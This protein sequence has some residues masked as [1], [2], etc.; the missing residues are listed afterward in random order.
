MKK[1]SNYPRY[2]RGHLWD[3]AGNGADDYCMCC[4]MIYPILSD[5]GPCPKPFTLPELYIP[6][7]HKMRKIRI[8]YSDGRFYWHDV[9]NH[10]TWSK[11]EYVHSVPEDVV[12]I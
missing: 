6:G 8:G 3:D 12:K 4:Q 7:I 11:S 2:D 1:E 10:P 9:T 5:P